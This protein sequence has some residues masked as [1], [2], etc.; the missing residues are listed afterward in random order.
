MF[1]GK[2]STFFFVEHYSSHTDT[3][4]R[5]NRIQN[6]AQ[7]ANVWPFRLKSKD[8]TNLATEILTISLL[9][10]YFSQLL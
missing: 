2:E 5:F 3:E 1:D 8:A 6:K 9:Q 10:R 4:S 7:T